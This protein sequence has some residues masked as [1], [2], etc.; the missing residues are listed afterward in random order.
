MPLKRVVETATFS[1]GV[2]L[3]LIKGLRAF[4]RLD[5]VEV[6]AGIVAG[7]SPDYPDGTSIVDVADTQHEGTDKIPSRPWLALGFERNL[8]VMIRQM[9]RA[10]DN[11]LRQRTT[12]DQALARVGQQLLATQ[13]QSLAQLSTPPLS[14]RTVEKKQA[15]R[16]SGRKPKPPLGFAADK[17]L[18][19]TQHLLNGHVFL[20]RGRRR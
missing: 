4:R 17:P 18:V 20:V 19:E 13:R 15:D 11:V 2:D 3:N 16:A 5:R 8:P 1:E 9:E 6:V 12:I 14:R 7:K 10:A